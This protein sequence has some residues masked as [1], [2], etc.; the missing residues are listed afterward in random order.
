MQLI[1]D[2]SCY[3]RIIATEQISEQNSKDS[4]SKFSDITLNMQLEVEESIIGSPLESLLRTASYSFVSSLTN[5][6]GT[7]LVSPPE[8]S[9]QN[10]PQNVVLAYEEETILKDKKTEIIGN[11]NENE[12]EN[13]IEIEEIDDESEASV[14]VGGVDRDIPW[15]EANARDFSQYES[16]LKANLTREISKLNIWTTSE[17]DVSK[18][19]TDSNGSSS[20]QS[21]IPI[22]DA[23]FKSTAGP[24]DQVKNVRSQSQTLHT[25]SKSSGESIPESKKE[26]SE[27]VNVVWTSSPHSSSNA[28]GKKTD[29]ILSAYYLLLI[30]EI[31]FAR[32]IF[33]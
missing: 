21:T 31:I 18:S 12:T 24:T 20:Q 23:E 14:K 4:R 26:P 8:S 7:L 6:I 29:L 13:E 5:E 15:L 33:C 16:E 17:K 25:P 28:A 30:L 10:Q 22:I 27:A 11:E 9:N 19:K 2:K 32:T 1:R 3:L